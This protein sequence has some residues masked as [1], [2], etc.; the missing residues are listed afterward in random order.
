MPT[1]LRMKTVLARFRAPAATLM[2]TLL[3]SSCSPDSVLSY[4]PA[5]VISDAVHNQGNSHFYWLPPMVPQPTPTGTFDGTLSP[6]VTICALAGTSCSTTIAT[7]TMT[8]GP[9]GDVIT[10]DPVS[11]IY[12]VNWQTKLFTLN[13]AINYRIQVTIGAIQIGL[14]DVDVASNASQF[15]NLATNEYIGLVDGRTLPIKFR[16]EQGFLPC[17]PAP[18]GLT[19]WWPGENGP[20]DIIGSDNGI[21]VGNVSYGLGM[22]GFAFQFGSGYLRLSQNYGGPSTAEV[23]VMAWISIQQAGP[24][25][26]QAILSS[27]TS[28]FVHFQTSTFGGAAV[29]TDPGS[30]QFNEIPSFAPTPFDTW[31]HVALTAKSGDIRIY[32]DGVLI[33]QLSNPFTYIT[34]QDDVVLIGN[35]YGYSRPFPGLVDE[36]QV[37]NRALTAG[38][39]LQV[40][41]A[42]TDGVCTP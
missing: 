36:L 34:Q 5:F 26:W 39:V 18:S 13:D 6:T 15:K 37:Y 27:T 8:G 25:A 29:Y 23:T 24:S 42:G 4:A 12:R 11:E 2:A 30:A 3:M 16:I 21:V 17:V 9:G 28:S 1:H 14:A 19:H 7:Y 35:G 41:N 38:E 22:R 32:Q 33:S 10:V 31:R 20:E 40:F